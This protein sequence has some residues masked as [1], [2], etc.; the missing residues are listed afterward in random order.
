MLERDIKLHGSEIRQC[1]VKWVKEHYGVDCE[2]HELLVFDEE[3]KGMTPTI[4]NKVQYLFR[5]KED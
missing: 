5:V 1:C 3:M 4:D 2:F